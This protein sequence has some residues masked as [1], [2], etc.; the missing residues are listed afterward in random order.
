LSI[1]GQ[2]HS[3]PAQPAK[4]TLTLGFLYKYG[5][6]PLHLVIFHSHPYSFSAATPFLSSPSRLFR[7]VF[8][9]SAQ[10]TPTTPFISAPHPWRLDSSFLGAPFL[11]PVAGP[12]TR[13]FP[14][15][16][17]TWPPFSP[18]AGAQDK[19]RAPLLLLVHGASHDAGAPLVQRARGIPH[20]R[21]APLLRF[22]L[23]ARAS[24]S[25]HP[26]QQQQITDAQDRASLPS[27][28]PVGTSAGSLFPHRLPQPVAVDLLP[29]LFLQSKFSPRRPSSPASLAAAI[30]RHR[31][32]AHAELLL[33]CSSTGLRPRSSSNSGDALRC[34][35]LARTG[36]PPSISQ[37][38]SRCRQSAV[39]SS[40]SRAS[41]AR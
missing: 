34:V 5:P 21:R 13:G 20:G 8:F 18:S 36:H 38:P 29:L 17:T 35:A 2:A 1:L 6:L 7:G 9:P 32:G 15:G 22:P 41:L 14:L 25:W 4:E 31:A 11:L 33:T 12:G 40:L 16:S 28:G 30:P 26:S 37:S 10:G 23:R 27:L 3:S 19:L 24:S 39:T